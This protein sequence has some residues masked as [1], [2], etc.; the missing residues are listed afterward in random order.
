MLKKLE[1]E[2]I[3][4]EIGTID[5]MLAERDEKTDPLGVMQYR[6]RRQSL[7]EEIAGIESNPETSA[8]I[9]LF[10]GGRPVLGSKGISS[11]FATKAIGG[12]QALVANKYALKAK[13][14]LPI[15]GP[16][17]Q[18]DQSALLITDIV[19]GSLG[20]VLT[21][22]D[23]DPS[24]VDSKLKEA[25]SETGDLIY[26]FSAAD[27]EALDLAYDE[28]DLRIL[29]DLSAFFSTMDG[30]GATIRVVQGD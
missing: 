1:L 7:L 3:Q 23:A 13:P 26:R 20:F 25:V 19:R 27:S 5:R 11:E 16:T 2:S 14:R 4:A 30:A 12:F 17:P 8:E 15:R 6:L 29:R 28:I 10:F 9:A 22:A 24:L 21:E 18:R